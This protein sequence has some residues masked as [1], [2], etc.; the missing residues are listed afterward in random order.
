MPVLLG[1]IKSEK[2]TAIGS[3]YISA[4]SFL[5][6]YKIGGNQRLQKIVGSNLYYKKGNIWFWNNPKIIKLSISKL[7]TLTE[8]I[9]NSKK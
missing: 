6:K 1:A 3:F 8:L 9:K 7:N 2:T 5:N 4:N